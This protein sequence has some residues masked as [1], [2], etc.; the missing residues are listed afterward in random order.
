[1]KADSAG[2]RRDGAQRRPVPKMMQADDM[3]MQIQTARFG[4][5]SVSPT[6]VF[7]F[8]RGLIGF[9]NHRHWVLLAD[10]DNDALAWLQS[11]SDS[12]LALAVVSP[13]RF[14]PGYRVRVEPSDLSA[15]QLDEVG[16]A[17]VLNIV[18]ENNG[19]LT[20]NLRAPLLI[21]LERRMGRQVVTGDDQPLQWELASPSRHL[22]KSA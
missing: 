10:A 20:I 14:A 16:Q 2:V 1:M 21:N 22:K 11:T 9:E 13:R 17:Y 12:K 8:P 4:Q 15:L 19:K 3:A 6:D 18:A 5:I 7:F